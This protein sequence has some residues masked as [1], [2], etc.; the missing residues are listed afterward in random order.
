M[1]TVGQLLADSGLSMLDARAIL[2]RRLGVAREWLI[3]H[4][5]TE[6]T[7]AVVEQFRSDAAQRAAG[8]PL[9]YLLGEK[10]FYGRSFV[11][12]P[13]VLVPRPETERL[14]DEAL[15]RLRTF[16]APRVLDLGTGCGCIAITLALE[17]PAARVAA[18]D[19][20]AAALAVARTN[21][22]RLGAPL[23]LH[24]GAW[25][26]ALPAA[27]VFD[28]I[29]SNPPYV[30]PGDPHLDALQFE[31]AVALTDGVDGLSSLGAIIAGAA[32]RLAPAGCLILEH[33]YDQRTAVEQ[34]LARHGWRGEPYD[35]AAGQP[36]GVV[37]QR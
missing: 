2:S 20:S 13:A 27:S 1:T 7:S 31:P 3:A 36:R 15:T 24:A 25:F 11:V 17:L 33:G 28:V 37:A 35:D 4:P 19:V 10:E 22:E 34:L 23:T 16:E 29:V 5:E 32:A 26:D 12:S 30:A 6:V 21:A 14:V 9:A 8:A 18:T